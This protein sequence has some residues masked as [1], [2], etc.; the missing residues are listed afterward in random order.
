MKRRQNQR[1]LA[2]DVRSKRIGYAV[3]E[4]GALLDAG[5]TRFRTLHAAKVRLTV[6]IGKFRPRVVVL[7]RIAKMSS[8]NCKGTRAV[9]RMVEQV[10]GRVQV[11]IA[12]VANVAIAET[13]LKEQA[14]TKYQIAT[15]LIHTFPSL[16]WRLP[17]PRKAWEGEHRNMAI[18]DAVAVGLAHQ[19]IRSDGHST[20]T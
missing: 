10:A 13:F 12:F 5:V 16:A 8:R 3:F 6:L 14:A 9:I 20:L 17:A 11:R 2:L 15:F 4:N 1:T 18:F 19:P 7:R